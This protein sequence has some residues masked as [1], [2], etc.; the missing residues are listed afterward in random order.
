MVLQLLVSEHSLRPRHPLR[1]FEGSAFHACFKS[2]G[3]FF[4]LA[5]GFL[6][7]HSKDNEVNQQEADSDDRVE[8][9]NRFSGVI[10]RLALPGQA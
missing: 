3:E 4:L 1:L 9:T 2:L 7:D 6:L 5:P 10:Y 8:M